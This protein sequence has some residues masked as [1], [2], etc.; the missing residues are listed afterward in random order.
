MLS[1]S[2][3]LSVLVFS[4]IESFWA[5]DVF[6][7]IEDATGMC[8]LLNFSNFS[9]I[10]FSG[11]DCSSELLPLPVSVASFLWQTVDCFAS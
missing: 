5:K 1:P 8:E 9:S 2:S 3:I 11:F 7:S 6:C 4:I 10:D